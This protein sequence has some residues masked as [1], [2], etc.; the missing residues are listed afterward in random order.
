MHKLGLIGMPRRIYTFAPETG[1]GSLNLLSTIGAAVLALAMFAFFGNALLSMKWGRVAGANPWDADTLEWATTSPPPPYNFLHLPVVMGREPLW[2]QPENAPVVT[3]L[4][5]KKREVL[6]TRL[7]DAEP[8]HRYVYPGPTV[9]PFLAA[10]ATG[11]ML[12]TGIFTPWAF[13]IGMAVTFVMLI[14]W[15]WPTTPKKEG[16]GQ[17]ASGSADE[18]AA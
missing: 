4:S 15:F 7:L 2:N 14:G 8:D 12:V 13:A 11:A 3:G 9:W 16:E 1:W 18:E 10:V 5:T 6:V 17:S